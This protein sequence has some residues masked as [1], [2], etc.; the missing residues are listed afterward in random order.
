MSDDKEKLTL[1]EASLTITGIGVGGGIMAVP[2]LV[3]RCGILEI[4]GITSLAYLLSLLLHLMIA[5]MVLREGH[6][7]QLMEL[8]AD[9]VF[10]GK[11]GKVVLWIFFAVLSMGFFF[12][13]TAYIVGCAEILVKLT[14]MSL[15]LGEVLTYA[16]AAG[17]VFFGLKAMGV[18]E[19]WAVAGIALIITCMTLLSIPLPMNSMSWYSPDGANALA[20]FG[21]VMFSFIGFWSIP[22]AVKGLSHNRKLVPWAVVIGIGVNFALTLIIT[23]MT[24]LVSKQVTSVAITGWGQAVGPWALVLGSLCIFLA[25]LT[26]YWATSYAFAVIIAERLKFSYKLSWLLATAPTLLLALSGLA[27]FVGFLRI[28]GGAIA[29]SVAILVVPA[30]RGSRKQG[31]VANPDFSL[32]FF[33]NGFFQLMLIFAYLLMAAGSVIIIE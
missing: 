4:L 22:Q 7:K 21:M 12:C 32:G 1:I 3:S 25:L 5:E 18:I 9:F 8:L 19:K 2:Y 20:L 28:T 17:V 30:L 10:L 33:G 16:I 11:I 6:T 23:F 24:L 26:S 27:G 14:G 15:W 13:L 29:V 31:E